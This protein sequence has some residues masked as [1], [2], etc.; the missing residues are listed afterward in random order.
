[1][2]LIILNV[3]EVRRTLSVSDASAFVVNDKSVDVVRFALLTG[4]TDIALD[5][6]SALRVMYQRPGETEVRAQTL[7]YYD[8]DGIHNFYDWELL[9]ADLAEKGTL[10]V[11]LCIL[12]IDSEVEEWH[13]TPYQIRVLGSI[14]TDDS[15]EGDET[16]TPTVAQRVAILES[17]IQRVASGAPIVVS[18][19]SA[20][21]DTGQ[22]YVL[23]TDGNWYYH[24]GTA[25]VSGGTYGAVATDTTLTQSGLPADAKAVGD[26]IADLMDYEYTPITGTDESGKTINSTANVGNAA[27]S[28]HCVTY[29]ISGGDRV[30]IS[31]SASA[32]GYYYI[33]TD[34]STTLKTSDV[35]DASAVTSIVDV[36]DTAP[37]EANYL[38]VSYNHG[39]AYKNAS[40]EKMTRIGL[41]GIN[42]LNESLSEIANLQ[43]PSILTEITWRLGT[44]NAN[45]GV[46][47]GSTTRI[48]SNEYLDISSVG[49]VS[50]DINEGYEYAVY[51]FDSSKEFIESESY[52]RW[53]TGK[54]NISFPI[55]VKYLR[56]LVRQSDDGT[57]SVD[58]AQQFSATAISGIVY[59]V[60][61]TAIVAKKAFDIAMPNINDYTGFSLDWELGSL[62]PGTGKELIVNN[63]IRSK[64]I[65]LGKGSQIILNNALYSHLIYLF[66]LDGVYKSDVTWGDKNQIYTMEEDCYARI[67]M[68]YKTNAVINQEDIDTISS[69][70]VVMRSIPNA[71]FDA[72]TYQDTQDTGEIYGI[73][74]NIHKK[75]EIEVFKQKKTSAEAYGQCD[76]KMM[77]FTDVHGDST[78]TH[79]MTELVNAWGASYF[80]VAVCGGD[81][82]NVKITEDLSWYYT[83]TNNIDIPLLNTVGNH[84]AW[85]SISPVTMASQID[86]YNKIIAPI[87]STSGISQP[88]NASVNGYNY[89]YKD[90]NEAVRIIVIDCMYW[91]ATQLTWLENTLLDARTNGLHV[92]CI[93]H[94]AFPLAS[95]QK[96]DCM[97]SKTGV[98]TDAVRTSIQ[99]AEA[100]KAFVDTG[101]IFIAWVV[102][103]QHGDYVHT[104][105]DY[106]N[107]FVIN[108]ASFAQ[109][110]SWLLKNTD[111]SKYNYDCL[112]YIA[113]DTTN[114][115]IRFMRIGAN[116]DIFGTQYNGLVID[117]ANNEL[118]SSY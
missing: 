44:F 76:L 67:L 74:E 24:N 40:A 116:I 3:D 49:A 84:D 18:S 31:G 9:A 72:Y 51:C 7:T 20:M 38:I 90:F 112:T 78:R 79:R 118:V 86:V 107:Q 99:A 41:K 30:R 4:F 17:M 105:P 66:D 114:K 5:E 98:N 73:A 94:A 27:A 58:F 48:R 80:D 26:E 35:N 70:E 106:G 19:A 89:Y 55:S 42:E 101:G 77:F 47:G 11:A 108:L 23:S 34:G 85:S 10:T 60:K 111:D 100:V 29:S 115:N 13:T 65:L 15:D 82:A 102:G 117:Y 21:T 64:M 52:T 16:I 36:I 6:H 61:E 68:R 71:V 54:V 25:W 92:L 53:L 104:L 8:T 110:A 45:T 33:F 91:D 59:T 97:W 96:V 88:E 28:Y 87:V 81:I 46:E 103:H 56:F 95:M 109:R 63:R 83:A 62:Q 1:M 12:R 50:F 43:G 75:A 2:S 32:H 39:T 37:N 69:A 57:A 113:V 22:I 93:S 14:H